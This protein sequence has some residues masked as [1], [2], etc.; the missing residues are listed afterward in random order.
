MVS[1]GYTPLQYVTGP[2]AKYC[3]LQK[4]APDSI[5]HRMNYQNLEACGKPL[6]K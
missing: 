6:H 5:L 1:N 3:Y 4:D 2:Y